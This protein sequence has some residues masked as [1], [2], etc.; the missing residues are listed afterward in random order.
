VIAEKLSIRF[1]QKTPSLRA[2]KLILGAAS[3]FLKNLFANECINSTESTII[4][5]GIK[6]QVCKSLF[7]SP[8]NAV[9]SDKP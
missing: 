3:P 2:H 9:V 8:K 6:R 4:V 1:F 7:L 5:P